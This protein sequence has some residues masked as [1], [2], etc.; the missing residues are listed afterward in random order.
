MSQF[1]CTGPVQI[2]AGVGFGSAPMFVGY[3]ERQPEILVRPYWTT[4]LCDFF[5]QNSPADLIYDGE[6]ALLT[7]EVTKFNENVYSIM[8]DRAVARNGVAAR[9]HNT[10]GEIGTLV[11]QEQ[12]AFTLWFRFPYS[13]KAAMAGMPAGYRWPWVTLEGPD[14][15]TGLG[16]VNRKILLSWHALRNLDLTVSNPFGRGDLKLYDSDMSS[17]S[18]LQTD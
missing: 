6:D 2:W 3:T 15:L 11:V 17:V 8:A 7:A 5:G 10:P 4:V 13:A 12:V 14:R 1:W 18:G 9:G 16:T